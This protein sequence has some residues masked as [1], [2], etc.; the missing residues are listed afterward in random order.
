[1]STITPQMIVNAIIA[2]G[3]TLTDVPFLT[4]R[5]DTQFAALQA[6]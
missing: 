3:F 1:M 5:E 6:D 4:Y 2:L